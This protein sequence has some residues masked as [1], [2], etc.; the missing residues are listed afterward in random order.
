M[1][2]SSSLLNLPP[3]D[4]EKIW[5][6]VLCP[7]GGVALYIDHDWVAELNRLNELQDEHDDTATK[8]TTKMTTKMNPTTKRNKLSK[9][10]PVHCVLDTLTPPLSFTPTARST[11]RVRANSTAGTGS[12][13]TLL[14]IALCAFS[15]S[16]LSATEPIS[17]ISAF[18]VGPRPQMTVT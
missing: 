17:A 1:K 11:Q 2:S 9:L 18:F 16:F 12:P 7:H 14:L 6:Y 5:Q 4:R 15:N 10:T 13:S 8:M 3:L